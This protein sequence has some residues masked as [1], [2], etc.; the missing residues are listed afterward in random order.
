MLRVLSVSALIALIGCVTI[1]VYFPAAA[2]EEAADRFIQDVLGEDEANQ[3]EPDQASLPTGGSTPVMMQFAS[4]AISLLVTAAHAQQADID[5]STPAIQA[6]KQRMERRHQNELSS[7]YEAGAIGFGRDGFVQI[8]DR[9]AV[10]LAERREMERLVNEENEDRRAVYREIAEA[11]NHPE[12]E[13][14]IRA[15][16]AR[17]WIANAKSGWYY[18]DESGGWAQK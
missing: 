11:N 6:I 13:E 17:R 16:F 10:G 8:R 18:Q 3:G 5:I 1:N 12:W 7:Y 4:G 15:T 14:Q 2:A 9:S